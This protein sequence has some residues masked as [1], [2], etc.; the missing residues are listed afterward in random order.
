MHLSQIQ[1]SNRSRIGEGST[2]VDG[3]HTHPCAGDLKPGVVLQARPQTNVQNRPVW[4]NIWVIK[5]DKGK[6]KFKCIQRQEVPDGKAEDA[7]ENHVCQALQAGTLVGARIPEIASITRRIRK[8]L[9]MMNS[10]R[11][12]CRKMNSKGCRISVPPSLFPA[13]AEDVR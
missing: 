1:V 12:K 5:R 6:R 11:P 9:N 3:K 8:D 4:H 2:S 7:L 13:Y 10:E